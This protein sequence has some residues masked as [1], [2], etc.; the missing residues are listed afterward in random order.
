MET[1]EL[2]KKGGS[3][4]GAGSY[5]PDRARGEK[6]RV[7]L[8]VFDCLLLN[9]SALPT[10]TQITRRTLLLRVW[11]PGLMHSDASLIEATER[12]NPPQHNAALSAHSSWL[13]GWAG[14][15]GGRTHSKR[16]EGNT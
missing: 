5:D 4:G 11:Q 13:T 16:K 10:R 3:P 9:P 2:R 15:Q 12:A 6:S 8:F 1:E 14:G 7:S